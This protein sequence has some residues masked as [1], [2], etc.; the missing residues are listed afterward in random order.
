VRDETNHAAIKVTTVAGHWMSLC[1]RRNEPG[2]H[3]LAAR[4][5]AL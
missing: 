3:F 1:C 5:P 4:G 2:G